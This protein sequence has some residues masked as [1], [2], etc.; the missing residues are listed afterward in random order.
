MRAR[1]FRSS[2]TRRKI[3]KRNP[4][5]ASPPKQITTSNFTKTHT[6]TLF[7]ENSAACGQLSLSGDSHD[8]NPEPGPERIYE[9]PDPNRHETDC[10]VARSSSRAGRFTPRFPNPLRVILFPSIL[11]QTTPFEP[12]SS[13]TSESPGAAA[14]IL[15]CQFA[16][17]W[18]HRTC[19]L[20][21]S[22]EFH[23]QAK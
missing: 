19:P 21:H 2:Q 7:C 6:H 10:A 15:T 14:V 18:L 4:I 20:V 9:E 22:G 12:S 1:A 17:T 11:P 16:D 8:P 5:F 3:P 23:R 13:I